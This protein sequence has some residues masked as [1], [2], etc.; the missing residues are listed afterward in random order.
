MQLLSTSVHKSFTVK[1]SV[2]IKPVIFPPHLFNVHTLPCE[3]SKIYNNH[4]FSFKLHISP[5]PV[6]EV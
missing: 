2:I 6:L 5:I 4:E 3:T 1:L